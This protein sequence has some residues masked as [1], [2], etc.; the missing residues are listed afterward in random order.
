MNVTKDIINDLI[1]LYVANECSADTRALV[2]EY[3]QRNPRQAEEL[4][5]IMNTPIPGTV[6]PA[7]CLDE[8]RAFGEGLVVVDQM[9]SKLVP[10]V[11]RNSGLKVV[12]RLT[13]EEERTIVGGAMA[14]NEA[15]TRALSSLPAGQAVVYTDGSVN[16]CRVCVPDHAG[17]E[18][19]L[20]DSPSQAEVRAHMQGRIPQVV[21][22][23]SHADAVTTAEVP[24][25]SM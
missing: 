25:P 11:I 17:R 13:A 22:P 12:H 16:A 6:P 1:P 5:R 2:E 24:F 7:K 3:L 10:D 9:P 21:D 19:Y 14:L 8:V 4:R 15:Q 23:E 20:R 18:G